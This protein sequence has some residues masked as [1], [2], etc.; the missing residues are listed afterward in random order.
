M[1]K[2]NKTSVKKGKKLEKNAKVPVNDILYDVIKNIET[3]D[4]RIQN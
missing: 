4:K 3:I 1:L 2:D